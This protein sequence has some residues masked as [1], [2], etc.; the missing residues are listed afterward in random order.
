MKVSP[1]QFDAQIKQELASNAIL[2]KAAGMQP[3]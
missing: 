2:A 3:E 1:D